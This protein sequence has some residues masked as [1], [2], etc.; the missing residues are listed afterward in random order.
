M[1]STVQSSARTVSLERLPRRVRVPI[2]ITIGIIIIIVVH[3]VFMHACARR[4][5]GD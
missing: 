1:Y 4:T 3:Y 5:D 2:N